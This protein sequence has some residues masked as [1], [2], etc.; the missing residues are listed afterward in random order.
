MS[1]VALLAKAGNRNLVRLLFMA[2]LL[3]LWE[4]AARFWVD[5]MFLS[6]PSRVFG[7]LDA[8]FAR[9]GVLQAYGDLM[10][11]LLI[12]FVVSVALGQWAWPKAHAS[13]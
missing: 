13:A 5:P 1:Q 6:P 8:L 12:A 3:L 4:C 11:E 2:A 7:H 10:A 9:P